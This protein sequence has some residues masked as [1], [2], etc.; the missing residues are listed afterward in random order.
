[1]HRFNPD[2][3]LRDLER[4]ARGG[5]E[6]AGRALLN[7]RFR[8]GSLTEAWL[9]TAPPAALKF[10][11]DLPVFWLASLSPNT[12]TLLS[13][14]PV[15]GAL[16]PSFL[17]ASSTPR[18]D[19]V[20]NRGGWFPHHPGDSMACP[21]G[22]RFG[23]QVRSGS[24]SMPVEFSQV[25]LTTVFRPVVRYEEDED[26]GGWVIGGW[27]ENGDDPNPRF[28]CNVCWAHWPAGTVVEYE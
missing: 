9:H 10:A 22:H 17:I 7:E 8:S 3:S 23:G 13:G 11:G 1:M 28:S 14:S 16:M 12:I 21:R 27:P 26:D 15:V 18:L 20:N 2:Q 25:E 4:R 5:D 19:E 24:G 6:V